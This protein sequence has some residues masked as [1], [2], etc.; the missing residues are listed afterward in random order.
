[1]FWHSIRL[2]TRAFH[3]WVRNQLSRVGEASEIRISPGAYTRSLAEVSSSIEKRGSARRPEF[4]HQDG[5]RRLF[6]FLIIVRLPGFRFP[7]NVI[8]VCSTCPTATSKSCRPNAASNWIMSSA[9]GEM[10]GSPATD[11]HRPARPR[12]APRLPAPHRANTTQNNP[13]RR[14]RRVRDGL[15]LPIGKVHMG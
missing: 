12:P 5:L 13:R 9:T 6:E 11:R 8:T 14:S 10:W 3:Y 4:Q 2:G 7:P 1:M 15:D